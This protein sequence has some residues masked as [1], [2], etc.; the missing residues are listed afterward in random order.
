MQ[1]QINGTTLY[2]SRNPTDDV[3]YRF[4]SS[5]AD[6]NNLFQQADI[7]MVQNLILGTRNDLTRPNW[8]WVHKDEVEVNSVDFYTYP[9]MYDYVIDYNWPGIDGIILANNTKPQITGDH[10]KYFTFRTTK[11]GDIVGTSGSGHNTWV[12]GTGTY[13]TS[14]E[15]ESRSS[16]D[17]PS[18]KIMS[19]STVKFK[20]DIQ[21]DVD[22]LSME[23]FLNID[24]KDFDVKN[25]SF[26]NNFTPRWYY[27]CDMGVLAISD[28][29]LNLSSLEIESGTIMEIE[30]Y[31][32]RDVLNLGSSVGWN[33]NRNIEISGMNETLINPNINLELVS[34]IPG[35][36]YSEIRIN[37]GSFV[38]Y[39]ESSKIEKANLRWYNN[40]GILISSSVVNLNQG[41]NFFV[42]NFLMPGIYFLQV[43]GE[44]QLS[45]A[46]TIN[47]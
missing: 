39:I 36:L 9:D 47:W 21:H 32:K 13:L 24:N 31:A 35:N 15:V 11:V 17:L 45:I 1:G 42:A 34:I 4:I 18:K 37:N 12:C 25:V 28:F 27:N 16:S 43:Q 22:I 33:K 5:D 44:N 41:E 46:K 38:A 40:Q 3:P 26:T 29:N 20:V 10:D 14:E 19:G 8:A 30:L 7:T 6:Y 2:S 23:F